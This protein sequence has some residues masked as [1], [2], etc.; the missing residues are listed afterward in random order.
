M[1]CQPN[2]RYFVSYTGV[3]LPFKLVD[4]LPESEIRNR[5]AYFRA[6][7]DEHDRLIGFDKVVYAEIELAHRYHYDAS[8][9]LRQAEIADIDGD[10]TVLNFDGSQP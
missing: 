6:Y 9:A 4:P 8:G 3:S 1:A 7:F 2:C 10:M 5:N